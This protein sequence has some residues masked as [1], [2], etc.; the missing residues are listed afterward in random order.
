MADRIGDG[1]QDF[2]RDVF[3]G[4]ARDGALR[5]HVIETDGYCLGLDTPECFATAEQ[6]AA[7]GKVRL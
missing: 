2:G 4:L 5:G 3:P 1:V 6:L 7:S